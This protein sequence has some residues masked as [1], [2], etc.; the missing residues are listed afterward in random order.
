MTRRI[1]VVMLISG[2][3]QEALELR[4]E[5]LNQFAS[6]GTE[7]RLLMT[8]FSPSSVESLAEMELAASGIL[9]RVIQSERE[10]VDAVVIWGGH[11]P[12]LASAREVVSIPV[13][14][15]GMASM[16]IAAALAETFILLIQLPQ[17]I[18]IAQRQVRDL[19]LLNRCTGIFPVDLPVLELGKRDNFDKVRQTTVNAIEKSGA[20]A[21]C[22]GCMALNDH[23]ELLSKA[24][25]E[26]HPGVVVIHPGKAAIRF[27]ELVLDLG[28]SHS[29]RSYP[30][31]V[32]KLTFPF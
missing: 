8:D 23:A 24:L 31:P 17:V 13:I 14:G 27:A 30:K 28:I 4:R 9:K 18:G 19:D 16:Y 11:D 5:S 26:T 20:D 3:S 1:D 15:P 29:K 10:G 12:S 7:V 22:F 2:L 32:K 21:V 6:K 25:E